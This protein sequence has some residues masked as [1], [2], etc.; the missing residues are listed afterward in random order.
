MK[1]TDYLKSKEFWIIN[2]AVVFAGIF[3]LM[4]FLYVILPFITKA[5]SEVSVPKLEGKKLEQ[6]VRMLEKKGLKYQVDSTFYDPDLPPLQVLSQNP[7]PLA[8]VKPGR[9]IYIRVNKKQPTLVPLPPYD[10]FVAGQDYI[11]Y[12][13][14]RGFNVI[15]IDTVYNKAAPDQVVKVIYNNKLV[16][17]NEAIPK[18]AKVSIVVNVNKIEEEADSLNTETP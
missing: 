9:T 7:K 4:I 5:S 17:S 14:N 8:K 2:L 10:E 11:I 3:S 6:A 18:G 15:N 13:R 16:K 1:F 12:L